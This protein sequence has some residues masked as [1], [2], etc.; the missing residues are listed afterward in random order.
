MLKIIFEYL[1][2]FDLLTI[3][4]F[5]IYDTAFELTTPLNFLLTN[6]STGKSI[7]I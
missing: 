6:K 7:K 4:M 2:H 3:Q 1:S 5:I